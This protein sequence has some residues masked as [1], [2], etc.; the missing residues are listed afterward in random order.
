MDS[1]APFYG[2]DIAAT[3]DLSLPDGYVPYRSCKEYILREASATARF[4]LAGREGAWG[5][6]WSHGPANFERFFADEQPPRDRSR[7]LRVTI[8]QRLTRQDV[9]R[10]WLR[11]PEDMGIRM[12]GFAELGPGDPE[13][14]WSA[15]ARRHAAKWRKLAASGAREAVPLTADDY[16]S[17]Y[18]KADQDPFI[19]LAYPGIIRTL[20]KAHGDRLRFIGSRRAGGQ[21]DAGFAFLHVPEATH[22]LHVSAF[23]AGDAKGDSAATGLIARWFDECRTAGVR[24]LDFGFF[25]APGDPRDWKGF[26]R[27]KAQFGVRLLRY[28]RPLLRISGSWSGRGA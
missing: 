4:R 2:G 24:F 25:W 23:I 7:P 9:P 13:R 6:G 14:Q 17:A 5:F 1:L 22:S 11:M 26:S 16:L 20:A 21:V 18:A 15:H 27:F 19:K 12:T 28:P 3:A 10:G 8:W